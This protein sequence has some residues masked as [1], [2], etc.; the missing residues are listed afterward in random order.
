M[1]TA[2]LLCSFPLGKKVEFRSFPCDE[3]GKQTTIWSQSFIFAHCTDK[4]Q[5]APDSRDHGY[6]K[7]SQ[8]WEDYERSQHQQGTGWPI[9]LTNR[10]LTNTGEPLSKTPLKLGHLFNKGYTTFFFQQQNI[11]CCDRVFNTLLSMLAGFLH[12]IYHLAIVWAH[13]LSSRTV[14]S[15]N[16]TISEVS[17]IIVLRGWGHLTNIYFWSHWCPD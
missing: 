11:A 4:V 14:L 9:S 2:T 10:V 8:Y 13:F 7:V 5:P 3:R 15:C 1:C 12:A 6:R 17:S 16:L